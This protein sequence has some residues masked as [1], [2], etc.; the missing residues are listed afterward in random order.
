MTHDHVPNDLPWLKQLPGVEPTGDTSDSAAPSSLPSD[1]LGVALSGG[2]IRSASLCLGLVQSM[3]RC[4]WLRHV[5]ILS[6]VSGGGYAGTFLG[7]YFDQCRRFADHQVPGAAQRR[8]AAGLSNC[9]SPP[10]SWLRRYANYLAPTGFGEAMFN[11]AAFWRNF[12]SLHVVLGLF[13]LALFGIFNAIGYWFLGTAHDIGLQHFTALATP[14]TDVILPWKT[15]LWWVSAELTFWLATLPLA[16][17]YWL[18]SQDHHERFV[19][20]VFVASI[21]VGVSALVGMSQPLPLIVVIAA[22]AWSVFTWFDIRRK[23]GH[24]DPNSRFRLAIARNRL[25]YRLAFWTTTLVVILVLAL[26]DSLGFW[27]AHTTLQSEQPWG[28]IQLQLSSVT[29]ALLALAPILRWL[30]SFV[31]TNNPDSGGL[32][33]SFLQ[34]PYL[35]SVLMILVGV[36]IPLS[37]ISLISHISFEVGYSLWQ[38]IAVAAGAVF[39]SWLLGRQ[40]SLPFVN[41]SGPLTIYAARLARV[42]LGAVNPERHRHSAGG[43]VTDVISGDDGPFIEYAPHEAGGPLHLINVSVNETVD[44]A[45]QRGMRDRQA[46]NM[47]VGPAGTNLSRHWHSLWTTENGCRTSELRPIGNANEIHPMRSKVTEAAKTESLNVRQWMAI[48]GA[49]VSPGMGRL[50]SPAQSLLLTLTNLR[51]GYWWDSGI[52]SGHRVLVP[53]PAGIFAWIKNLFLRI[54][55]TQALLLGELRGRFAGPWRRHFYLS[56]GGHFE[57]TGAYELIRRRVPLMIVC[58]AGRDH[59]QNASGLAELTRIARIDFAAEIEEISSDPAQLQSELTQ[60]LGLPMETA[61]M[62]GTLDELL[63]VDGNPSG[64]HAALLKVRYGSPSIDQR[65]SKQAT[66]REAWNG[67]NCSWMLYIKST[68]TG[69]EPTDVRNYRGQHPD[70][71]NESTADQ[72]FDEPQWE[73]YRKLGEHIGDKLFHSMDDRS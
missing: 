21:L 61:S 46:E 55:A 63:S 49:A 29:V 26:I 54:F 68:V 4:G 59:R 50:T 57:N 58:D 71:P 39:L 7:R 17:A 38:G 67:R 23:E 64:K 47:A 60:A 70:F 3:A 52:W 35:S 1:T 15:S 9:Q 69:D 42:F 51:L 43:S 73:S 12:L 13:L 22:I 36:V 16:L 2:G 37:I 48:S 6:T 32:L 41:R 66:D 65:S 27:L 34:I 44:I 8:V 19:G 18:V 62:L 30:A 24:G 40:T 56:D 53:F 10:I 11:F 20:T 31:V 72:F 28:V 14:I 25:T 33:R 5:D 45:S